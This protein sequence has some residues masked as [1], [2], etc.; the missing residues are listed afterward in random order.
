L[1]TFGCLG[2]ASHARPIHLRKEAIRAIDEMGGEIMGTEVIFA[3][4]PLRSPAG[5]I[6]CPALSERP[7]KAKLTD[8]GMRHVARPGDLTHVVISGAPVT[9]AGMKHLYGMKKLVNVWLYETRVTRAG[10]AELRRALPGCE[11]LTQWDVPYTTARAA[12]LSN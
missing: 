3:Y 5:T 2:F 9:D 7:E 4:V 1:I 10:A 8:E 12:T 11:I 6:M